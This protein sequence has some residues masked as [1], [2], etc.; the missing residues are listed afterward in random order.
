MRA[1]QRLI[2]CIN[3]TFAS[4]FEAIDSRDD[5]LVEEESEQLLNLLKEY[6]EMNNSEYHSFAMHE[7]K[8][9]EREVTFEEKVLNKIVSIRSSLK[10]KKFE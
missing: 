9:I 4:L 1:P 5:E 2:E 8:E 6:I 7:I 3:E 10:T